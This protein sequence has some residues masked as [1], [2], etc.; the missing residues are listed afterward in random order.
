MQKTT[1]KL[2]KETEI[3]SYLTRDPSGTTFVVFVAAFGPFARFF[4]AVEFIVSVV[5]H[6]T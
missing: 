4:R 1:F 5:L 2:K 3:N 6:L